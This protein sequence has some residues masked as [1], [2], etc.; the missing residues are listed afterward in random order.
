MSG[1]FEVGT[2]APAVAIATAPLQLAEEVKNAA[3]PAASAAAAPPDHAEMLERLSALVLGIGGTDSAV[4]PRVLL[5]IKP[6][7]HT[8]LAMLLNDAIRDSAAIKNV[9]FPAAARPALAYLVMEGLGLPVLRGIMQADPAAAM[10]AAALIDRLLDIL[11]G[12]EFLLFLWRLEGFEELD[13]ASLIPLAEAWARER[14]ANDAG[15]RRCHWPNAYDMVM[16][17]Y[18]SRSRAGVSI[19]YPTGVPVRVGLFLD[20]GVFRARKVPSEPVTHLVPFLFRCPGLP[21][22][23][24]PDGKQTRTLPGGA[25]ATAW[26]KNGKFHRDPKE[27]PALHRK[28][29][30]GEYIEYCVDGELHRDTCD[31]P[32]L[33]ASHRDFEGLKVRCEEFH[34]RG[35]LHRPCAEGPAVSYIDG[36]GNRVRETYYEHGVCHR[37]PAQ[38]PAWSGLEDGK[39]IEAYFTRG[40]HHRPEE[41]GPAVTMRDPASGRL[42]SEEY[43]SG[44]KRHRRGGPALVA[45]GEDGSLL[46]EVWEQGGVM[47]RDPSAGPAAIWRCD[48]ETRVEFYVDGRCHRDPAE[49]PA[50]IVRTP[51]GELVE[52]GYWVNGERVRRYRSKRLRRAIRRSVQRRARASRCK[53]TNSDGLAKLGMVAANGKGAVT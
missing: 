53:A 49:G 28:E 45:Y 27:G 24:L 52:A 23:F 16:A 4:P 42:I 35:K 21:D 43:F 40:Q 12:A 8:P 38:G 10:R 48:I 11:A 1:D 6:E 37:D 50:S 3:E 30:D 26:W 7:W 17:Y 18:R 44:G 13:G 39:Y 33:I 14:P 15:D 25:V 22:K 9:A 20:R 47:H 31:G 2:I 29:K 19:Q 51:A 32:A 41:D 34:V 46:I 5:N 36:D